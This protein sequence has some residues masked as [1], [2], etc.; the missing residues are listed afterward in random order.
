MV[1]GA[2]SGCVA[3]Q[4]AARCRLRNPFEINATHGWHG[5]CMMDERE[6][7]GVF[8]PAAF[9]FLLL[10]RASAWMPAFFEKERPRALRL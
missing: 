10:F 3:A 6:R 7:S 2:T 1:H 9:M 8:P 5:A 4:A